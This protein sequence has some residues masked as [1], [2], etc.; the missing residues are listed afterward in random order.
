MDAELGF[1]SSTA[2]GRPRERRALGATERRFLGPSGAR[3]GRRLRPAGRLWRASL[4]GFA[5]S[6]AAG[7]GAGGLGGAA[8]AGG[9]AVAGGGVAGGGGASA[10]L[11]G[12]GGGWGE[13][14]GFPRA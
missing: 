12:G 8:S 4:G 14:A 11:R 9:F 10:L 2:E 5:G 13:L 6:T 7:E 3:E 1:A